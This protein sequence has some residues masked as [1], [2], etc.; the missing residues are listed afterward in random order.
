MALSCVASAVSRGR[1]SL[2]RS[3][4]EWLD[5]ALLPDRIDLVPLG[6]VVAATAAELGKRLHGDPAD[7]LIV[8]TA[9]VL[10]APLV[11]K[12]ERIRRSKVIRTVW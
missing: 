7:R 6:P 5:A 11:T 2:D 1:I 9:L 8:A 4:R 10:D 3:V 12:D